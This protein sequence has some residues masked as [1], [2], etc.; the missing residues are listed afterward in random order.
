MSDILKV[1]VL[2]A[3]GR[4]GRE[5]CKAVTNDPDLEL[6]A[7]VDPHFAGIDIGQVAGPNVAGLDIA[8]DIDALS[9]AGVEVVIDFTIADATK[10]SMEW[11]ASHGVHM[12]IGTTGLSDG[13][14]DTARQMFERAG[15]NCFIAANFAV[16]AVLMNRFVEIAARYMDGAE[17]IEIH[18]DAK[19]D[20]PSG[21]ALRLAASISQGSSMALHNGKQ[22]GRDRT[23]RTVIKEVRG[24]VSEGGVRIH[25]LRLPGMVAHHEVVFG[26]VGQSLTIRHDA[27]DRTSFMPGIIMATKAVKDHPGVTIGL[28]EL[29]GI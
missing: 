16:G 3:G 25:S 7:A 13:D 14:I 15:V 26:S 27:F 12:V 23:E 11:C 10:R 18:H 24:G 8:G 20:A 2:G 29:L 28:D 1:G 4:M 19:V 17:V 6:V 21:T 9:R 22:Y 5:I